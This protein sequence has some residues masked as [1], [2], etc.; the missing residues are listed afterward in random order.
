MSSEVLTYRNHVGEELTLGENG[1]YLQQNDLY[2]YEWGYS[3][4]NN[5]ISLFSRGIT[6]KTLPI[7]IYGAGRDAGIELKNRIMEVAD[8][9][10]LAQVPGRIFFGDYYL[11]CYIYADGISRYDPDHGLF[12]T[13]ISLV[14]DK[15][16]WIKETEQ[17]FNAESGGSGQ[18][19]DF[20][21]DFPYDFASPSASNE[22]INYGFSDSDFRLV[23]YG[24]VTDPSIT[25]NGHEYEVTGYV[26]SNEYLE[27]DSR[28]KTVTLVEQD[29]TQVN[30]FRYRNKSSYIFE[31]IPS[32]S[33]QVLW[34]GDFVFAVTLYEERSEPKWT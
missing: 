23:I 29:G 17:T 5:K 20:P 4:N 11:D 22:L 30:W 12:Y 1:S 21:F 25:I 27:I 8:K 16:G 6:K 3:T 7:V 33:S 15:P 18:N 26:G 2:S 14:T 10:I 24:E 9:D 28:K 31:K 13:N 32:G 34:N 19:L